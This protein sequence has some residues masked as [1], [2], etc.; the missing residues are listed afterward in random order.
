MMKFWM[1]VSGF[2]HWLQG[3]V[4]GRMAV[5]QRERLRACSRAFIG[6]LLTGMVTSWVL[7]SDA[8]LPLLVAPM[9]A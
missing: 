2:F 5:S 6:I 4:P 1:G 3:F 8:P 9:G 7:G